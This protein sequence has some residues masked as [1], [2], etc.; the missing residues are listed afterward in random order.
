M[1]VQDTDPCVSET[2]QA[3][4]RH[5]QGLAGA[6]RD[7]LVADP[8]LGLAIAHRE[9]FL[10]RMRMGRRALARRDPLLEQTQL[11][12]TVPGRNEHAGLHTL[13]PMLQRHVIWIVNSHGSNLSPT[14]LPS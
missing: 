7:S 12:R 6:N 11:C 10:N 3:P 8:H 14:R 5:N 9:H 13:A 4:R 1:N 2:M